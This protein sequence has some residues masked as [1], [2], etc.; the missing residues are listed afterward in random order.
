MNRRILSAVC[1]VILC[2]MIVGCAPNVTPDNTTAATTTMPTTTTPTTAPVTV[3]FPLKEEVTLTLV[4]DASVTDDKFKKGMEISALWKEL[5]QRTN[6]RI[7]LK[8]LMEKNSVAE[9]QQLLDSGNYGDIIIFP[10]SFGVQNINKYIE[11]GKFM[12]I[13]SYVNNR[14]LMPNVNNRLFDEDPEAR[15]LFTSVDGKIY[16]LGSS[17]SSEEAIYSMATC[18][19]NKTWLDMAEM[20]IPETLEELEAFFSWVKKYDPNGDGDYTDEIPYYCYPTAYTAIEWLQSLWG[21]PTINNKA[22]EPNLHM[23]VE[24]GVVKYIPQTEAYKD[25]INTMQKWY[26]QGWIPAEY[27]KGHS[28]ENYE[29]MMNRYIRANG[30]PERVAFYIGNG[31]IYRNQNAE[32]AYGNTKLPEVC[33]YIPILPPKVEGYETRWYK[34]STYETTTGL[35]AISSDCVYPEIALAWMDQFYSQEVTERV[36]FGDPGFF[37]RREENGKLGYYWITNDWS[38]S[39]YEATPLS[40]YM[41]DLPK[42]VTQD[43]YINRRI[44]GE[45]TEK[46]R[47]LAEMYAEVM[48]KQT[49]VQ[50]LEACTIDEEFDP[51]YTKL[52]KILDKFQKRWITGEGSVEREWEKYQSELKAAGLE[53]LLTRLQQAY[54][55]FE[56]VMPEEAI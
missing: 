25:F 45:G 21:L 11:S 19:I 33:E 3:E 6:V 40:L 9:L 28:N 16:C 51:I 24:D 23:M 10:S 15:G 54:D 8:P 18:W 55:V 4:V 49:W 37:A 41:R 36:T 20:D 50:T 31:P 35:F 39:I 29:Y 52:E 56:S 14:E 43:E 17:R 12:D 13:D 48:S 27:F 46:L 44:S 53:Q 34:Y 22:N 38:L 2:V 42:A 26:K 30:Q 32:D 47:K 5:Y 1:M 7:N